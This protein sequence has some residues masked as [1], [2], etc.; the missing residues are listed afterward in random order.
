MLQIQLD[1]QEIALL[2]KILTSYD[3]ELR[4]EMATADVVGFIDVLKKEADVI[5]KIL[6]H[7]EGEHA[8]FPS[9]AMFGEY[10]E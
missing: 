6:Q 3:A 2:H 1:A 9:E 8:A 10:T 4:T 5:E 7:L